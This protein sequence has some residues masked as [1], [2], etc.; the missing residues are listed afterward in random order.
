MAIRVML[1]GAAG[2]TSSGGRSCAGIARVITAAAA[3]AVAAAVALGMLRVAPGSIF[4][5]SWRLQLAPMAVA[6]AAVVG[7]QLMG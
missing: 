7:P 3:V 2:V 6:A 5:R 1:A 4:G